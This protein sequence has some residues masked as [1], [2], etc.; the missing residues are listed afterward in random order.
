MPNGIGSTPGLLG[1]FSRFGGDYP[2]QRGC[3]MCWIHM[4]HATLRE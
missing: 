2:G 3:S 4:V 1:L